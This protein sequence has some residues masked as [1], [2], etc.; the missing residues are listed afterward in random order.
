M[1]YIINIETLGLGD[2]ESAEYNQIHKE[3]HLV[4]DDDKITMQKNIKN[5]IDALTQEQIRAKTFINDNLFDCTTAPFFITGKYRRDLKNQ[6][7]ILKLNLSEI[8][9]K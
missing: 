2:T 3:V 9:D 6:I 4:S 7:E 8:N 5:Q 1:Q